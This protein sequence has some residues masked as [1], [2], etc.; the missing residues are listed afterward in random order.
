LYEFYGEYSGT[1]IARKH[2][3]WYTRGL[4]GSAHFRH[5]MNQLPSTEAQ[6]AAVCEFFDL[7]LERGERL[8]Y[9][10]ELAA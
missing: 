2:I 5:L 9:G 8:H 1:R 3:S 7:Q 6:M 4:P 10:E